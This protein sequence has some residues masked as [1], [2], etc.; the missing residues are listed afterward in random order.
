MPVIICISGE[1]YTTYFKER[2]E[3]LLKKYDANYDDI[4]CI[5]GDCSGVDSDALEICVKLNIAYEIYKPEWSKYGKSAG[6]KRNKK[7]I[8][9]LD[10]DKDVLLAFHRDIAS[11]KGTLNTINLA[12]NKGVKVF[13]YSS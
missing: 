9:V 12:K 1:R 5:F 7:M 10:K 13:L 6:P 8:D 11:S 2:I 4:K 3:E